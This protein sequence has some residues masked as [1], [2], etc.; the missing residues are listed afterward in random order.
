MFESM[1]NAKVRKPGFLAKY[2]MFPLFRLMNNH[3]RN[4]SRPIQK[5]APMRLVNK[6]LP[7]I[8]RE[9]KPEVTP[10]HGKS[11]SMWRT[12]ELI[13]DSFR[14]QVIM[15]GNDTDGFMIGA[16]TVSATEMKRLHEF[17]RENS[18]IFVYQ[19]PLVYYFSD[20]DEFMQENY[21]AVDLHFRKD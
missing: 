7:W 4:N 19:S 1:R 20:L 13:F 5:N 2:L 12:F 6:K 9:L 8:M 14:I 21:K 11:D 18:G 17:I 15:R 10:I 3:A 16:K